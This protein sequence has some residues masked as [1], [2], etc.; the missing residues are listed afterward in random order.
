MLV[1]A[2]S[3]SRSETVRHT[4][5]IRFAAR[6]LRVVATCFVV[7]CDISRDGYIKIKPIVHVPVEPTHGYVSDNEC[8]M[9]SLVQ[10]V[11]Q[12]AW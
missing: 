9:T 3:T 5:K 4:S 2:V 10:A 7:N 12:P 11:R 6:A 1:C 8:S